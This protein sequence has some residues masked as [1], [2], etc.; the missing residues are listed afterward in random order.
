MTSAPGNDTMPRPG[1]K[2]VCLFLSSSPSGAYRPSLP[3]ALVK[4]GGCFWKTARKLPALPVSLYF[5][6]A[7]GFNRAS[8]FDMIRHFIG[9]FPACQSPVRPQG[10]TPRRPC[11]GH[12]SE[13]RARTAGPR[14]GVHP[15]RSAGRSKGPEHSEGW[16]RQQPGPSAVPTTRRARSDPRV[17]PPYAL[18]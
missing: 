6:S 7:P 1:G 5:A 4:A 8:V 14:A 17:S 18:S 13:A 12:P 15:R 9:F 16:L 11:P 3:G 2:E 10:R